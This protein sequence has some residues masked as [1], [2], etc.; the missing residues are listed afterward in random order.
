MLTFYYLNYVLLTAG[1]AGHPSAAGEPALRIDRS[2]GWKQR[3]NPARPV[4]PQPG[5]NRGDSGAAACPQSFQLA[6][7]LH[8]VGRQQL[9]VIVQEWIGFMN[10]DL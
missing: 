2:W 9:L 6:Q 5:C 3:P 1:E 10:R 4:R 8:T 7:C